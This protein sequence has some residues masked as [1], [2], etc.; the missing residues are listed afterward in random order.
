[1]EWSELSYRV[2]RLSADM[3]AVK[4]WQ[5]VRE[6]RE[7]RLAIVFGLG[8]VALAVWLPPEQW[9]RFAE[10]LAAIKQILL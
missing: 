7:Q 2:G 10:I 5:R 6:R 9:R 8:V 3:R 1:M 4:R